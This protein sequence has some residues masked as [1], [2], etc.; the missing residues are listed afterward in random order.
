M[1]WWSELRRCA[2]EYCKAWYARVRSGMVW[3]IGNSEAKKISYGQAM[4]CELGSCAVL[5]GGVRFGALRFRLVAT[6]K[7]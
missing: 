4:F 1:A 6:R 3:P 5:R 7:R 2:V